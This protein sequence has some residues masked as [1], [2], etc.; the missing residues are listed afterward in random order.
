MGTWAYLLG[1]G[2]RDPRPAGPG[3]HVSG[4]IFWPLPAPEAVASQMAGP[5]LQGPARPVSGTH[6]GGN[7][8]SNR[9]QVQ[10]GGQH[11]EERAE[12]SK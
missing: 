8:W 4:N 11:V 7:S 5:V 3:D 10:A 1:G 6:W 9:V 12:C 2:P